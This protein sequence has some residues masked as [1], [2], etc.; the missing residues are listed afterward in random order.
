MRFRKIFLVD[1]DPD[2][3]GILIDALQQLDARQDITY[4]E[5]GVKALDM[6]GRHAA[7]NNLPCLIVLDL[8]MP[9]LTGTQILER[10]KADERFKDS[11]R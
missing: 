10:L 7:T 6:L 11:R 5:N 9:K 2:D 8:N 3:R 1:D 4:A